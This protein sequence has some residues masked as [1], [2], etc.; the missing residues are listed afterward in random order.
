[1]EDIIA[2]A[3]ALGKKIADHPRTRAFMTAARAVAENQEAQAIMKR[4]QEQAEKIHNL[5]QSGKPIEVA[6]KRALANA[7][8]D[9]AGHGLLK[10]MMKTQADYLEMMQRINAAIDEAAAAAA[11]AEAK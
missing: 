10:Q 9:A 6:D 3:R 4:L 11:G 2:D 5:E 1:M 7:Q 8:G